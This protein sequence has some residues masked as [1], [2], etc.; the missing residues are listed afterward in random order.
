MF[1]KFYLFIF[2]LFIVLACIVI[3][4][5]HAYILDMDLRPSPITHLIF[6]TCGIKFKISGGVTTP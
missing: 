6:N 1:I 4:V 2:A 3:H 5:Y